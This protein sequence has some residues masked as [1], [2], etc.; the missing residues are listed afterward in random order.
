VQ[1]NKKEKVKRSDTDKVKY[2]E[3]NRAASWS[4]WWNKANLSFN[5]ALNKPVNW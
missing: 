5:K 2:L 3:D 4:F 1:K